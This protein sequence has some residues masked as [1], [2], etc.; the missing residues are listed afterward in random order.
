MPVIVASNKIPAWLKWII[1]CFNLITQI[2]HYNWCTIYICTV[3]CGE[4]EVDNILIDYSHTFDVEHLTWK[5]K[6]II[7]TRIYWNSYSQRKQKNK[8][9]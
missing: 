5:H 6:F 3:F 9:Q 8:Q 4:K 2:K 1:Q 7:S